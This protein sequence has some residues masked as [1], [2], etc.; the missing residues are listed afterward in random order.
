MGWSSATD[1]FDVVADELIDKINSGDKDS[2]KVLQVLCNKLEDRDWDCQC[3]SEYYY[4]E[5]IGNILGN[6]FDEG[7]D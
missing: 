3:E 2:L 5:T 7:G 6:D 1:I 4:H